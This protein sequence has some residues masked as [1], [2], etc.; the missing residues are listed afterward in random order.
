MEGKKLIGK[1]YLVEMEGAYFF[2]Y[3]VG[4][5][6]MTTGIARVAWIP[7]KFNESLKNRSRG[8]EALFAYLSTPQ[9]C[10]LFLAGKVTKIRKG[11]LEPSIGV[12]KLF[13]SY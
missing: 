12:N 2:N 11:P 13:D 7:G 3:Y 4:V 9:K 6:D 1:R 5:S 10:K 8:A